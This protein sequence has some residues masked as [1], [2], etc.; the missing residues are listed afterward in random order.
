MTIKSRLASLLLLL[1]TGIYLVSCGGGDT[2]EPGGGGDT[3][4]TP[5][6]NE[7]DPSVPEN[8]QEEA[9]A[10]IEFND[11]D[12]QVLNGFSVLAH[13][14]LDGYVMNGS[15][16]DWGLAVSV[17]RENLEQ[18]PDRWIYETIGAKDTTVSS[19]MTI[20]LDGLD[21]E[22]TYYC[23]P[24]IQNQKG[25]RKWGDTMEFTTPKQEFFLGQSSRS[26][27]SVMKG[28]AR[29]DTN[30]EYAALTSK[31]REVKVTLTDI[32][33]E[34]FQLSLRYYETEPGGIAHP[35]MQWGKFDDLQVEFNYL[36]PGAKVSFKLAVECDG[37]QKFISPTYSIISRELPTSGMVDLGL[38]SNWAACNIGAS[39]PWDIGSY[40]TYDEAV[41]QDEANN[42][43]RLPTEQDINQLTNRCEFIPV[44]L[45]GMRRAMLVIGESNSIL[46]PFGETKE[47]H[48]GE[49]G[50]HIGYYWTADEYYAP[51]DKS[52]AWALRLYGANESEQNRVNRVELKKT[53]GLCVRPVCTRE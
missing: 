12:I 34:D 7:D 44:S 48:I 22:Q 47:D 8:P 49:S 42:S 20:R 16:A 3:P 36:P 6:G 28:V 35:T 37:E 21:G 31:Y 5:G 1:A 45:D 2:P 10:R 33:L 4:E 50:Y 27:V 51:N 43:W 18:E 26:A 24:Y 30:R 32:T 17:N 39:S 14:S 15:V 25:T 52:R 53:Y 9:F 38:A 23:R 46:L 41:A 29:I 40:Y 11:T 13:I 19:Y